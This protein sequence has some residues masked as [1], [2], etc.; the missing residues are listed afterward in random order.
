[1]REEAYGRYMVD[2]S[3]TGMSVQPL[4]SNVRAE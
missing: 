3:G 4:A 2:S 1:M